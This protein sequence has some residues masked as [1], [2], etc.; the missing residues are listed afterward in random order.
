MQFFATVPSFVFLFLLSIVTTIMITLL[1]LFVR[2]LVLFM[3]RSEQVDVL[4]FPLG[5]HLLSLF[6]AVQCFFVSG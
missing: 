1:L 5:F 2:F 6:R 4:S 3:D